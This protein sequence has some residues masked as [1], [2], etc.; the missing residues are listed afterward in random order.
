MTDD[1]NPEDWRVILSRVYR[2]E[3]KS[4]I[5]VV[6]MFLESAAE[7]EQC[8]LELVGNDVVIPR[9]RLVIVVAEVLAH[10]LD[11]RRKDDF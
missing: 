1:F 11:Y 2:A 3:P 4:W 9:D 5:P 8:P 6:E 10:L 7:D